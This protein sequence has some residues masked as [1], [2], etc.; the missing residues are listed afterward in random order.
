M[1]HLAAF[2]RSLRRLL[3]A[4]DAQR[5]LRG[6]ATQ[7][8][9]TH[10]PASSDSSTSSSPPPPPSSTDPATADEQPSK[11]PNPD[12][13]LFE[14]EEDD[15]EYQFANHKT[16]KFT[17]ED[18]AWLD[19]YRP[20]VHPKLSTVFR[21]YTSMDELGWTITYSRRKWYT[22]K[23]I[24]GH[25][26]WETD[27]GKFYLHPRS[28]L[29][30]ILRDPVKLRMSD[31]DA[32]K[33]KRDVDL[34]K[35]FQT[36]SAQ[37]LGVLGP[38]LLAA[39]FVTSFGGKV[40]FHGFQNWFSH[41][42]FR[43]L[44]QKFAPEFVCE[45]ID[46]SGTPLFYEG[47]SFLM[48][49]SNLRSLNLANCTALDEWAIAR[50]YPLRDQLIHLD[51]SGC[52]GISDRGVQT[53]WKMKRLRRLVLNGMDDSIKNLPMIVMELE[54]LL[55]N[56]YVHGVDIEQKPNPRSSGIPEDFN[57]TDLEL[58]AKYGGET[59]N[60]EWEKWWGMDEND[61]DFKADNF[62]YRWRGRDFKND[63]EDL[64][65]DAKEEAGWIYRILTVN[66]FGKPKGPPKRRI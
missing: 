32:W 35:R 62:K 54:E 49:L 51:L 55:P 53:L 13:F 9:E 8:K 17:D 36:M 47:M 50:L 59:S 60:I 65:D 64:V 58:L 24:Y 31:F 11:P 3:P 19:Y 56:C 28:L 61:P 23:Q 33:E 43:S 27:T 42:N 7:P 41:E 26:D 38:E 29:M 14:N 10:D 48:R 25:Y 63:W 66:P 20:K 12:A 34:F 45:A 57:L 6:V 4:H 21:G 16:P 37:K 40:K 18:K 30:R 22:M 46:L 1:A 2:Q 52:H 5:L 44:P 15:E 39:H